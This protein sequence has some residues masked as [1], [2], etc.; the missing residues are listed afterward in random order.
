MYKIQ[1]K[2]FGPCVPSSLEEVPYALFFNDLTVGKVIGERKLIEACDNYIP[3]SSVHLSAGMHMVN[4]GD[5]KSFVTKKLII[6]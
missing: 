3:Y 6:Q 2:V 1:L 5:E 4:V